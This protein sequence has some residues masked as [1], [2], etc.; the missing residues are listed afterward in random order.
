MN[1]PDSQA[2]WAQCLCA[3]ITNK[4]KSTLCLNKRKELEFC[5]KLDRIWEEKKLDDDHLACYSQA[6]HLVF[7][8]LIAVA[9]L[10]IQITSFSF[11][12]LSIFFLL[13]WSLVV[14][15]GILVKV[16]RHKHIHFIHKHFCQHV[17][18]IN[19]L[20]Q[21]NTQFALL[22][23][24]VVQAHTHTLILKHNSVELI[25]TDDVL[26]VIAVSSLG[27]HVIS[28]WKQINCIKLHE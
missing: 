13:L 25:M 9:C 5:W 11:V 14:R 4:Q 19:L 17:M 24:R 27:I 1:H 15:F 3:W 12:I 21:S 8:Y 28:V 6:N 10:L 23:V 7:R 20:F 16:H 2:T 26:V 18:E 22:S